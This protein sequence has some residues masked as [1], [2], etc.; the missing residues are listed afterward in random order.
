MTSRM[1]MI[2]PVFFISLFALIA[3]NSRGTNLAH[4]SGRQSVLSDEFGFEYLP[5]K[6]TIHLLSDV[7]IEISLEEQEAIL[8]RR[9]DSSLHFRV[10]TGNAYIAKGKSTPEGIFTVQGKSREATSK[11][12]ENAKLFHWIGFNGNIGFHGLEGAGY[13]RHLGLRPSSHGCVRIG[14]DDA[15]KL[16]QYV[17]KGTPVIVHS[18]EPAVEM[19]FSEI[20]GFRPNHDFFLLT[21]KKTLSRMK[22]RLSNLYMGKAIGNNF[23]RIFMDGISPLKLYG[24]EIG[25]AGKLSPR[26]ELPLVSNFVNSYERADNIFASTLGIPVIKDSS[27]AN[28]SGH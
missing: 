12:F 19:K 14:R 10:S 24:F 26:Q 20:K 6:D 7:Y 27:K 25:N 23:G 22:K 2:L 13:Y 21:D 1:G 28:S 4:L 8:H 9:N 17:R 11:Q 5:L 16:Y 15:E 18:G 3:F